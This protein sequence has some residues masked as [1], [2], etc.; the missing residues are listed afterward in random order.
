M[1]KEG[2]GVK[3]TKGALFGL[4]NRSACLRPGAAWFNT[5]TRAY[6]CQPCAKDITRFAKRVAGY[7]ICFPTTGDA[8]EDAKIRFRDEPAS[9][10]ALEQPQ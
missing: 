8:A 2:Q 3:L 4:C 1:N 10:A 6:Y 5:S 7:H 9:P